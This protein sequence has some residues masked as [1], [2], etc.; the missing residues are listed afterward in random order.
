MIA[1]RPA[2]K[3]RR[4]SSDQLTTS[5]IDDI[6]AAKSGIGVAQAVIG[7][8]GG[9]QRV[10]TFAQLGQF[11]CYSSWHHGCLVPLVRIAVG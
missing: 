3:L 1:P 7:I 5:L 6:G 2:R 11:R 4:I 8:E 9:Y 10:R